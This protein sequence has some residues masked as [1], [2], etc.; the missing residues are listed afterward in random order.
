[1]FT[2]LAAAKS[3]LSVSPSSYHHIPLSCAHTVPI[4]VT[5]SSEISKN[6]AK[7]LARNKTT[8]YICP[9]KSNESKHTTYTLLALHYLPTLY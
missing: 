2:A 3:H 5:L 9:V 6:I 1:M 8:L 4:N 7:K